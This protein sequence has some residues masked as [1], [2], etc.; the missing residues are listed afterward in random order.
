[1]SEHIVEQATL[2]IAMG[3]AEPGY[4]EAIA[5]AATCAE[6]AAALDEARADL[7]LLALVPPPPPPAPAVMRKL[8]ADIE[9]LLPPPGRVSLTRGAS[10]VGAGLVFVA[11]AK[12]RVLDGPSLALTAAALAIAVTCVALRKT[13]GPWRLAALV[14]TSVVLATVA[15]RTDGWAPMVGI[16]CVAIELVGAALPFAAAMVARRRW[17]VPLS[18][19]EGAVVAAAGALAGH[20]ALHLTC[21]VRDAAPHLFAFHVGGVILALALGAAGARLGRVVRA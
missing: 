8:E 9:A 12:K 17:G 15:S 18:S 13:R 14:A 16:K 6:C 21:P 7:G 2:L 20:A 11:I 10:V 19:L 4:A 5:H 3:D 1:M